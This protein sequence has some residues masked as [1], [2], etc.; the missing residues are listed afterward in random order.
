MERYSTP[1]SRRE[2]KDMKNVFLSSYHNA[3]HFLNFQQYLIHN[4]AQKIL[5]INCD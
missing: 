1:I 5:L 4:K 2:A 3:L